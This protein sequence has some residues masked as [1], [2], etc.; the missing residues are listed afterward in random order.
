MLT[1][2]VYVGVFWKASKSKFG[3]NNVPRLPKTEQRFKVHIP[4]LLFNA[5]SV[6]TRRISAAVFPRKTQ[7]AVGAGWAQ[8]VEP[9]HLVH[10]G[11]T[12][13]TRVRATLVDV[14]ITFIS[15]KR[16][17]QYKYVSFIC[18]QIDFS[19]NVKEENTCVSWGAHT[20]VLINVIQALSVPTGVAGTIVFIDLTVCPC[21]GPQTKDNI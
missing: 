9:I 8:A 20:F 3:Y 13:H 7:R 1:L 11:S 4:V 18:H 16:E 10:T 14:H 15:C 2:H 6:H 21:G 19:R 12:T 5:F 17:G